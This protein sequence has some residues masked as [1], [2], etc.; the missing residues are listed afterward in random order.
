[1]LGGSLKIFLR[2][3]MPFYK[4]QMPSKLAYKC[5]WVYF[6]IFNNVK[7]GVVYIRVIGG[8]VPVLFL[9]RKPYRVSDRHD[10]RFVGAISGA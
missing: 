2:K 5:P 4:K 9:L 8:D 10:R 1:M 3:E 7:N 6:S